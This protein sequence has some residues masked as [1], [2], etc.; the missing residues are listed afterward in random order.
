MGNQC[1]AGEHE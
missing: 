1:C